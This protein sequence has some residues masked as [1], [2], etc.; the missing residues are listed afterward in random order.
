MK[1]SFLLPLLMLSISIQSQNKFLDLVIGTY[2]DSC[3]SNGI[4]VYKFNTETAETLLMNTTINVINPSYL[5]ISSDNKFIYSVNEN[6]KE[7]T[8]SSFWFV[9]ET[10]NLELLSKQDSKGADPCYIINDETNVI[11]ANYSEGTISVFGKNKFGALNQAKQ[12]IKH[13]G[14]GINPQR[15]ESPHVHMVCFSPDKKYVL[16]N[17]L[18]NDNIYIYKYNP[19]AETNVL[20]SG[21]K[22]SVKSGSGPRHLAFSNNGK[23]VYLL[24]ELDGSLTTFGYAG[25]SLK[26]LDETTIVA[27]DFKGETSAADIHISPDGKFLYATNRGTA[28]D[29]T[30]FEIQNSGKLRFVE[31]IPTGGKGPRNFTID[32][33][34]NFL[35]V[36]HQYTNNVVIFKIDK[37]SGK[38]ADTGKNIELCSPVCLVFAGK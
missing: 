6:G 8:V 7:S 27:S 33:A 22:V 16:A 31:R 35:L 26:K 37:T 24:Q 21:K 10:G 34:G 14:K 9:P 19:D 18:G 5:T 38:L 32:P 2:T 13:S 29:I 30:C 15:Q 4:Y 3:E 12:V 17:D 20:E 28:N 36:G 23:F 11:V 25:G 1:K